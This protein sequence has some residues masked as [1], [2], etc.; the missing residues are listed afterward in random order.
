MGRA[1]TLELGVWLLALALL[2]TSCVTLGSHIP[3]LGLV[4]FLFLHIK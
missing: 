3:S 1:E 4:F 2:L